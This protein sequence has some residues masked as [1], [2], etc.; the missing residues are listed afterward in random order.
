MK[1]FVGIYNFVTSDLWFF[2]CII[3][4]IIGTFGMIVLW[5]VDAIKERKIRKQVEAEGPILLIY[6][7]EFPNGVFVTKSYVE[8]L[9][10]ENS[11]FVTNYPIEF[12]PSIVMTP[13]ELERQMFSKKVDFACECHQVSKE[14]VE[15]MRDLKK[16]HVPDGVIPCS[17]DVQR[18]D[19]YSEDKQDE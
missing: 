6:T 8:K 10:K 9:I 5:I 2:I 1:F 14:L 3:L 4:S 17:V 11:P 7:R 12:S 18:P 19:D 13:K 16:A 15:V